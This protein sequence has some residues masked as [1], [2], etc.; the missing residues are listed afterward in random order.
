MIDPYFNEND[1]LLR[2][3]IRDFVE[4]EIL[5]NA[6]K[7][8]LNEEFPSDV[9]SKVSD[10]GLFKLGID[11]NFGGVVGSNM[12]LAIVTEELARGCASTAVIY[13]SHLSLCAKYIDK[14]GSDEQKA[15]YLLK[16]S[17]K[18]P[19]IECFLMSFRSKYLRKNFFFDFKF[20]SL[21]FSQ[22]NK[23]A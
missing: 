8:D 12:H 11:E 16:Y 1:I 13:A 18:N 22:F 2:N 9:I 19:L 15:S 17:A 23:I 3:T 20:F 5:P 21:Y 6:S 7:Y 4:R 14:F 10:M